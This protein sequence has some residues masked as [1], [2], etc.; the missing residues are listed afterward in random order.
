MIARISSLILFFLL[1]TGCASTQSTASGDGNR[2]AARVFLMSQEQAEKILATAMT[3]QFPG[4]PISRVEFPNKGYQ[5]TV[6]FLLDS[7]TIVA[8]MI[9]AKG[10]ATDGTAKDGFAFEVSN[11]GTMPLSG[12]TRAN[13]LFERLIRDASAISPPVPLASF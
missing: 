4:A 6:R 2:A 3:A 7:H 11:A 1:L 10:K 9:S 5:A 8:Y 12:G 13:E